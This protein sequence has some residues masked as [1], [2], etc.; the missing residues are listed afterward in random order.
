MTTDVEMNE[1]K[2]PLMGDTEVVIVPDVAYKT[3]KQDLASHKS[4]VEFIGLTKEELEK[5]ANDPFWKRLRLILFILFWVVWVG[6]LIAAILIVVYSPPCGKRPKLQFWQQKTGYRI[7]PF[8]FVDT[9]SN[10]VGDFKGILEKLDYIEKELG[11]GYI[12]LD[13]VFKGQ[14]SSTKNKIGL[15]ESFKELDPAVG[16]QDSLFELITKA[17]NRGIEIVMTADFNGLSSDS[18]LLQND[19]EKWL[20]PFDTN[21]EKWFNRD[22]NKPSATKNGKQFYSVLPE[23]LDLN[24]KNE[25]VLKEIKE[26]VKFWL[27][28]GVRGFLLTNV[29]FY[30]ENSNI[31]TVN[32]P[33]NSI[34]SWYKNQYRY[35]QI[36]SNETLKFLR[37][38]RETMNAVAKKSDKPRLLIVDA[39]D[40][41]FGLDK[42]EELLQYLGD[43]ENI[44]DMIISREFLTNRGWKIKN[45]DNNLKESSVKNYI[46]MIP[47]NKREKIGLTS[48][49]STNVR[50]TSVFQLAT[51]FLLRGNPIIYYGSELGLDCDST[52]PT[53]QFYPEDKQFAQYADD[54]MSSKCNH[55]IMPWDNTGEGFNNYRNSTNYYITTST[56]TVQSMTAVGVGETILQLH[57]KLIEIRKEPSLLWGDVELFSGKQ[58]ANSSFEIVIRRAKG[59]PT[60]I[61]ALAKDNRNS[62]EVYSFNSICEKVTPILVYPSNPHLEIKK[63]IESKNIYLQIPKIGTSVHAFK[64]A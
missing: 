2:T 27:D 14:Y 30:V 11:A 45:V 40:I 31:T 23:K 24:L 62:G 19:F 10:G 37:E 25:L 21:H 47:A 7:D 4:D 35:G 13:S 34:N 59:F 9:D 42:E 29:P 39:G 8:A 50:S 28:H 26:S 63:E 1:V 61:V 57:K 22:G 15:V 53:S 64:C 36:Y 18:S 58:T 5:F 52:T 38:I 55:L 3:P 43:K 60:I 20:I 16:N 51:P 33:Y 17:R 54:E 6:M 49:T 46:N 44:A 48:A 32:T 56:K 41:G 12:I